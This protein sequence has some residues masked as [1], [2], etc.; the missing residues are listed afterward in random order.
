[1][2]ETSWPETMLVVTAPSMNGVRTTPEEVAE[3]P[4]TPWTKSGTNAIVPSIAIPTSPTQTML[5]ATVRSRR[6]SNGRIGSLAP[7]DEPEGGEE[8]R[9]G[10][11]RADH[12]P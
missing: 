9:R 8:E 11:E 6:R 3:V 5:A 4:I 10:D 7:L 1:M 12:V 2:R